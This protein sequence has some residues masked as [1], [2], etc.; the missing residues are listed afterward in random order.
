MRSKYRVVLY[1]E[2]REKISKLDRYS[3]LN[4]DE[5]DITSKKIDKMML[6]TTNNK[7][8]IKTKFKRFKRNHSFIS[9]FKKR[10]ILTKAYFYFFLT[11]LIILLILFVVYVLLGVIK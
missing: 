7:D 9:F 10:K 1:K 5:N 3:F 8:D 4:D 2:N 11:L 6:S